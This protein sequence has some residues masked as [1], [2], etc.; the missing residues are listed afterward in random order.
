MEVGS[1]SLNDL[2]TR[3]NLEFNDVFPFSDRTCYSLNSHRVQC[4]SI[5]SYMAH[6]EVHMYSIMKTCPCNVYPLTPHFYIEKTGVYRGVPTIYV[7][8][9]HRLWVLVRTA[10]LRR[11]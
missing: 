2:M 4:Y 11:F 6:S 7:S 3:S 5:T 8:L 1:Y 10:S 9:K